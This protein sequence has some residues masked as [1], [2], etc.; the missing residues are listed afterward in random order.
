VFKLAGRQ[1]SGNW[2]KI[3]P[4]KGKKKKQ[5]CFLRGKEGK[6]PIPPGLG[7]LGEGGK[8]VRQA[9]LAALG[10]KKKLDDQQQLIKKRK[11]KKGML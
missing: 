5:Q 6:T 2:Q 10:G 3:G 11:G 7:V 1:G 8:G 9:P 4:E